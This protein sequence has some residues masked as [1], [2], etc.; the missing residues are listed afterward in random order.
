M[1]TEESGLVVGQEYPPR[2]YQIESSLVQRLVCAIDDANPR[3]QQGEVPPTLLLT[4][5]LEQVQQALPVSLTT[6]VLHGSTDLQL[7]L[8]LHAGDVIT[9]MTKIASLRERQGQMGKT[10]FVTFELTY[11][12]QQQ[13]LVARCR[14][15]LIIY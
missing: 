3:W 13:A 6:T 12:N 11:L 2:T 10:S 8:P 9:V 4:A 7:S 15:M 14:Q 1:S 5:G